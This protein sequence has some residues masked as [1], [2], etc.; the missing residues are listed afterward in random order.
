MSN[1]IISDY[2]AA[3]DRGERI[4]AP[5]VKLTNAVIEDLPTKPYDYAIGDK[6][7]PGLLVRIR[8]DSG[9]KT[10]EVV[11]KV[12]GRVARSKVCA[13]GERPYAKGDESVLVAA[14]AIIAKMDKGV[15]RSKEKAQAREEAAQVARK[16][17]TVRDACNNYINAKD[18]AVNTTKGY[19]AFRDKRL[20][21]WHQRQLASITEEDVG[22][23]FDEITEEAGP[24]AANN[25]IRF[26]RA[27]WKHHRRK[28]GLGDSPTI[29]FTKEGDNTK[30]WNSEERRIGYVH[31]TELK[32]WWDATE[33][34]RA[35]YVGDGD[36]AADYLQFVMLTGLRRREVS[37]LK[38][39]DINNRR[40]TFVIAE[41]KSKRLH[42][43][44]LTPRIEEILE[45]RKGEDRPFAIVEPR[46][47]ID[48]VTEWSEVP[49]STHD[50]RRTYLSHAT[51]AG[52]PMPILKALV[53][54]SRKAD[55]TDGY[56]QVDEKLLRESME[57]IQNYML[58][59]AGQIKN[60]TVLKEASNG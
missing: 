35:H 32:P 47:F 41:N 6:T 58:A 56:I 27:I 22:D 12:N 50:L 40:K 26:F 9:T 16:T 11:K 57:K 20:N 52:V 37:N 31:D 23:L 30:S 54:H 29:I 42:V 13:F 7:V 2:L 39:E 46:K 51:A 60:V 28:F 3:K 53:N 38:W 43:V 48:K 5:R 10:F 34:L 21:G 49:F 8:K 19:E 4:N 17:L 24:V 45:R 1:K 25:V 18:R 44:P 55:V 15:T 14:R 36:L 59:H 33:R